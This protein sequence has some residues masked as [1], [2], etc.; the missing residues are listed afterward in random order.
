M[1]ISP[2]KLD[3]HTDALQYRVLLLR[4]EY[5][6]EIDCL[7]L[8]SARMLAILSPRS[9]G[10]PVDYPYYIVSLYLCI[11]CIGSGEFPLWRRRG[12]HYGALFLE[13][14][15]CAEYGVYSIET[16]VLSCTE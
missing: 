3:L 8:L 9:S 6:L 4:T 13:F 16:V 10:M 2:S 1:G 15:V 7:F 11:I 14:E 12:F 5:N